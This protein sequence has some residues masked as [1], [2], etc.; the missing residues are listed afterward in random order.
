MRENVRL[1]ADGA[2]HVEAESALLSLVDQTCFQTTIGIVILLNI[3][4]LWGETDYPEMSFWPIF[5]NIFLSIF[6][7]EIGLKVAY[8]ESEFFCG[9]DKWWSLLDVVIVALGAFDLWIMPLFL[10]GSDTTS[11]E[12]AML[13]FLRLLRLLRL[14]RVFR[15]FKKLM[16]FVQA[17]M[18]MLSTFIWIFSVLFL[19]LLCNAVVLTHL[20]GHGDGLPRQSSVHVQGDFDY[21]ASV[22]KIHEN[23]Q[24]VSTSL[25]TL[26]QVTT[27]DNWDTIAEPVIQLDSRW[28]V[29]FVFFIAFASWT[30]I[31]VL[32]AV[33]SDNMIAASTDRKDSEQ[34]EQEN[35]QREFINFLRDAFLEADTDGNGLLDKEEFAALINKEFVGQ[36]MRSLGIHL[37]ED[38]MFKSWDMLDIDE[39]GTLTIDEFVTG[40]SYLQEGLSTKHI[41]NVDYSLKRIAVRVESQMDKLVN[42]VQSIRDQNDA[43]IGD[44]RIQEQAHLNTQLPLWLWQQWA[45]RNEGL[46]KSNDD[47]GSASAAA[48]AAAAAHATDLAMEALS[49]LSP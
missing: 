41:V 28:R 9:R 22:A 44:L 32:T 24:D 48:A 27:T 29:F 49:P 30:M 46:L 43:I 3:L 19:F 31:S 26:F 7:L 23:F 36:Q 33:A 38:E 21:S 35:R 16:T 10:Q 45:L 2:V 13:R 20:L 25:F 47:D 18:N 6:I 12:Y 14:L 40:L 1:A 8:H 39:S 37:S 11:S 15:M 42:Q 4:V 17:L 34:K 5:D